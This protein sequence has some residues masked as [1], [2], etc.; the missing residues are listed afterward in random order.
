MSSPGRMA[1][2]DLS[3]LIKHQSVNKLSWLLCTQ[4]DGRGS[5]Q[6]TP[7]RA[8][9]FGPSG[10]AAE[11]EN[12][13]ETIVNSDDMEASSSNSC[14]GRIEFN[15]K[16]NSME[17]TLKLKVIRAVDLPATDY[18]SGTS[19]PYVKILLLPDKHSKMSTSIKRRNLNP[20]W[21][22]IFEFEGTSNRRLVLYCIEKKTKIISTFVKTSIVWYCI[23][24]IVFIFVHLFNIRNFH[25]KYKWSSERQVHG[26]YSFS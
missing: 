13:R 15:I 3:C 10:R 19:D 11:R 7:A 1:H 2:Y 17:S 26:T 14:H 4:A 23:V 21:N 22:E 24:F 8:S 9:P 18:I 6:S 20:R 25:T 5:T 16:Y 12:S